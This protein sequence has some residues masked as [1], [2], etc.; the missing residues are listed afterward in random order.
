MCVCNNNNNNN[1]Y[2]GATVA[3]VLYID[4]YIK[5]ALETEVNS[6]RFCGPQ[7]ARWLE[8]NTVSGPYTHYKYT[9]IYI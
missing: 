8:G 5:R 6:I 1:I 7:T 9:Y 3:P 4:V 2:V